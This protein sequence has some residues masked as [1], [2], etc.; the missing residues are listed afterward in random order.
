MYSCDVRI[1]GDLNG[2]KKT[3]L[4]YVIIYAGIAVAVLCVPMHNMMFPKH[5][6]S[7]S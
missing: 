6:C 2:G 3:V 1:D 7:V 4:M 5:E